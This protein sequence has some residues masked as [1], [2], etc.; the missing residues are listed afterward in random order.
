M[1]LLEVGKLY[2]ESRTWW[3]ETVQYNYRGVQHELVLFMHGPTAKEIRAVQK[4]RAE[5]RLFVERSLIILLFRFGDAIPWGD[6]PYTIHM[7]PKE[8]RTVP[9]DPGPNDRALLQII[10]VDAAN[11]IIKAMRVISLSPEFTKVLHHAIQEQA[12]MPFARHLYNGE[13]EQLYANSSS[14]LA[15]MAGVRFSPKERS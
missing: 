11:G 1:Y 15:Q 6:A 12:K 10:L 9:P 14:E 2:N 13:L 7:V 5:F 8:E 3:P 4:D